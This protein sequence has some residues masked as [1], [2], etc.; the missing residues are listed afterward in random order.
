MKSWAPSLTRPGTLTPRYG[1]KTDLAL[2]FIHSS[3]KKAGGLFSDPCCQENQNELFYLFYFFL[4]AKRIY[5]E[6]SSF[7]LNTVE[8]SPALSRSLFRYSKGSAWL[9]GPASHLIPSSIFR[10]FFH[11]S[12]S[13]APGKAVTGIIHSPVWSSCISTSPLIHISL[14]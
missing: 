9:L 10:I 13:C 12:K 3:R 4:I 8:C 11:C 1:P 7:L 5:R 2:D 6:N 14:L